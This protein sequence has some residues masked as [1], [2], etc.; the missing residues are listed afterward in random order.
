MTYGFQH[1]EGLVWTGGEIFETRN[2]ARPDRVSGRYGETRL[3]DLDVVFSTAR[4]VAA[5]WAATPG[6]RRQEL[7]AAWL[8]RIADAVEGIAHAVTLEMGKTIGDAR[9]EILH[10]LKEA[11]FAVAE[12]SRSIGEVMPSARPGLRNMTLRRPRGVIVAS[13]PWNYPVLTPLRKLAP[14]FAHGNAVVLK[15]SE[16]SPA[17]ACLMAELS[18]GL[19]PHGLFQ[20]V[21]G[22]GR[23]GAAITGH[24]AADGVTFTGSV[25]TGKAVYA[26]AARNLA[27]VQLE[28][29]GKNGIIVHDADDLDACIDE[30]V[31]GA[32]EN[33]GQR[34]TGISRVLVQRRLASAV[35]EGIAAR[36]NRI[37]VG[38][39]M[40][41]GV[42]M[43]PM[44]SEAHFRRVEAAIAAGEAEGA[45]RV[46][47]RSNEIGAGF[48]IRPTLF[49]DVTPDMMLAREEVF[50]PVLSM[51]TYDSIDEALSILNGVDYGLAAALYSNRNDV[52]QRFVNEA[53]AG[54]L[55]VNH[56]SSIDTNMPFVGIKHSGVGAPSIGRSAINF[57][58]TEH[59]VYVKS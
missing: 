37:V 36:M 4:K 11:R 44:A 46:T 10:S 51:L 52:V 42:G 31:A 49:A 56:Q 34:C 27:E 1:Q 21:L 57:Y 55:H 58:T 25:A 43:G 41:A 8:D 14:A 17:A 38:D 50:G 20:I 5:E 3:D 40:D 24:P 2:P 30:V 12:A 13:T 23:V 45:R 32:L 28:L 7:T 39:G 48:F 22:G 6:L 29:G 26:A 19:F 35:E 47:G 15:P 16:V 54:M 33:G 53:E 9:G 18:V 59:A